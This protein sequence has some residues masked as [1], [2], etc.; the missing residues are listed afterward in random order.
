MQPA[1]EKRDLADA[2][3]PVISYVHAQL[4]HRLRQYYSEVVAVDVGSRLA[5][6]LDR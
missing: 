5:A 4:G 2:S 3:D 6:V 1:D